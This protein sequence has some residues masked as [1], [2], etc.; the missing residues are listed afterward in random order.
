M[1]ALGDIEANLGLQDL[2]LVDELRRVRED[3]PI[4]CVPRQEEGLI[5]VPKE[6]LTSLAKIF[7]DGIGDIS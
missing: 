1:H 3:R 5:R 2:A 6:A 4:A 7:Q